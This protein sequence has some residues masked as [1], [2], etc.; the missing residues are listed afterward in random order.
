[1]QKWSVAFNCIL[2]CGPDR[3][4]QPFNAFFYQNIAP[5]GAENPIKQKG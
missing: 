3:A 1:V 4:Y 2:N 5:N